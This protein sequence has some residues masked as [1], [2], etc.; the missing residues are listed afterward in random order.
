[1]PVGRSVFYGQ[2][3]MRLECAPDWV[4]LALERLPE[5]AQQEEV[6]L[7][8]LS[9]LLSGLRQAGCECLISF[10]EGLRYSSAKLTFVHSC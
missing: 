7:E 6:T 9:W 10:R 8:E 1:M 3:F 2:I 4:D 5:D